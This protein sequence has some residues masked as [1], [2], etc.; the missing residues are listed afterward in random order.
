VD[1][2][3]LVGLPKRYLKARVFVVDELSYQRL[4]AISC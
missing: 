1:L 2:G 3:R 4:V